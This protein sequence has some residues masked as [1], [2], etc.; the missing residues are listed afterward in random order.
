[1][2]QSITEYPIELLS[3]LI[4]A[5]G[6]KNK[7]IRSLIVLGVIF[8][9]LAVLVG[10]FGNELYPKDSYP[11]KN[12][13]AGYLAIAVFSTG[14]LFLL[15]PV[16]YMD[17]KEFKKRQAEL[18][19]KATEVSQNPDKP[20]LAWDLARTKLEN[21]LNRNLSQV[22]SIFFLSFFLCSLCQLVLA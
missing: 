10:V 16:A 5:W 18:I 14:I 17:N 22:R 7:T 9:I 12:E 2:I 6:T 13:I 15:I 20:Q 4:K 8:I 19:L 11:K 1:M 21:Y 3:Q